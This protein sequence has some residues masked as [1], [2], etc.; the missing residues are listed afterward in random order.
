M[1][2]TLACNIIRK[3]VNKSTAK[4]AVN[5]AKFSPGYRKIKK[6]ETYN[7]YGLIKLTYL[8]DYFKESLGM[9]IELLNCSNACITHCVEMQYQQFTP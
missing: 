5:A 3:V 6:I 9:Y 1:F 2:R 7:K 8:I 4:I